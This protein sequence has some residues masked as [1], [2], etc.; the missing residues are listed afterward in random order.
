MKFTLELDLNQLGMLYAAFVVDDDASGKLRVIEMLRGIS[1]EIRS[2]AQLSEMKL[3][4]NQSLGL[5][6]REL[7]MPLVSQDKFAYFSDLK[8]E[9]TKH[10]QGDQVHLALENIAKAQK[11]IELPENARACLMDDEAQKVEVEFFK[12]MQKQLGSNRHAGN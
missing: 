4:V 6:I 7:A 10:Q 5:K 3:R 12:L 2:L 11:F 8:K 9:I 1:P